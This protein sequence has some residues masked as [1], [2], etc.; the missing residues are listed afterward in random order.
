MQ[1]YLFEC[2]YFVH[3]VVKVVVIII[4]LEESCENLTQDSI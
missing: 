3:L 2:E 1:S 4:N